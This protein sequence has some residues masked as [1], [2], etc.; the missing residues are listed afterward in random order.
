MWMALL[1]GRYRRRLHWLAR[2]LREWVSAV[3]LS[4]GPIPVFHCFTERLAL[5]KGQERSTGQRSA[6]A[7][8][9]VV[10]IR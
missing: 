3:P 4:N 9:N 7:V 2:W 10:G 8:R 5:P 6:G 1:T